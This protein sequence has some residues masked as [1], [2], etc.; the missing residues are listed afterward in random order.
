MSNLS[1]FIGGGIKSV[2]SGTTALPGFTTL[3][4]ET[5]TAVDTAKSFI[6]IN[7]IDTSTTNVLP[8]GTAKLL[9]STTVQ[10]VGRRPFNTSSTITIL[11][12]VVEYY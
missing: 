5:I 4:E 3:V 7:G 10:V 12:T 9:N 6:S 1:E 8:C 2:Q 11:W